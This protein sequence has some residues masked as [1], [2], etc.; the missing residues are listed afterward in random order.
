M[1]ATY[2]QYRCPKERTPAAYFPFKTNQG[3]P[4]NRF[5]YLSQSESIK[6]TFSQDNRFE[7]GSI[8]NIPGKRT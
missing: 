5:E 6:G 2:L 1:R 3:L 4:L 7:N 8:Y